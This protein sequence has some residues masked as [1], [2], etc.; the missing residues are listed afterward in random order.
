M[1]NVP[2]HIK[3]FNDK[4]RGMNQMNSKSLILSAQEIR[5]LHADIFELLTKVNSMS[6]TINEQNDSPNIE[7]DGGGF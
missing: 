7:M 4:V 6:I 2:F 5:A 1:D 3:E